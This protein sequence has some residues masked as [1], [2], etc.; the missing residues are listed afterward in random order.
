VPVSP[1]D[2]PLTF[3]SYEGSVP[4]NAAVEV[5]VIKSPRQR[6]VPE[7]D[8]IVSVGVPKGNTDI[9]MLLLVAVVGLGHS[10]FEV[11]SH[12]TMSPFA[13]ALDV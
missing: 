7:D 3:Q 13:K 11:I 1:V 9:V 5:T 2:V 4:S 8:A 10:S 12:V 6:V